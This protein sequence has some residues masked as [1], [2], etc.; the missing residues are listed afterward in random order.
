MNPGH[1][2]PALLPA[3]LLSIALA[4]CQKAPAVRDETPRP[5]RFVTVQ[6]QRSTLALTLPA[7]VRPRIETRYGFRIGG[8]IAARPVSVGDRVRAGQVIA[9]LDPREREPALRAARSQ[10]DA[11]RTDARLAKL[12]LDRLHELRAR[13]YVSQAQVDRQQAASEAADARARSAHAQWMQADNDASYQSLLADADGVVTAVEAEAGQVVAAGQTVLRIAPDGDFELLVHVPE[14]DLALARQAPTWQVRIPALGDTTHDAA[15]RELAPIA[16]PASR[17]YAMRLAL[18][19]PVEGIALGM[20]AVAQATRQT[21]PAYE[22]PLTS[23]YS[24]DGR[25][26]VWRIREDQSVELVEV[27]TAG[28]LDDAVRVVGGLSAGDRV[29]TAGANRLVVGQRVRA[30][31][32]EPAVAQESR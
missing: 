1:A 3:L 32:D 7:E 12:E 5:V 27:R 28:F 31:A 19:D 10:L 24:R 13:N 2:P 30:G 29:V 20:S 17:T 14:R 18:R 25:P 4:G 22:L 23:L 16:D 11:A 8:K 6:A 9:R 21:Q 26:R 15:L